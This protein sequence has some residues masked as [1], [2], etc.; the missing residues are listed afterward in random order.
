MSHSINVFIIQMTSYKIT[1][2]RR[3]E[4]TDNTPPNSFFEVISDVIYITSIFHK[5]LIHLN[6]FL[7]SLR[8]EDK[9]YWYLY[10]FSALA[11][12]YTNKKWLVR[13]LPN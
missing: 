13:W 7:Y 5:L 4:N 11:L 10:N 2:L 3:M 6:T 1:K 9:T 8:H 12:I